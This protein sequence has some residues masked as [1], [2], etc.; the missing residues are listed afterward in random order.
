MRPTPPH[1]SADSGA[2]DAP[3]SDGT[4]GSQAIAD[5]RQ[6]SLGVLFARGAGALP[7]ALVVVGVVA[8]PRHVESEFVYAAVFDGE[9]F[10]PT[11]WGASALVGGPSEARRPP[12]CAERAPRC[13]NGS[14][15]DEF[16]IDDILRSEQWRAGA[17]AGAFEI[18]VRDTPLPDHAEPSLKWCIVAG[19]IRRHEVPGEGLFGIGDGGRVTHLSSNIYAGSTFSQVLRQPLWGDYTDGPWALGTTLVHAAL[20]AF[21][22]RDR[23]RSFKRDSHFKSFAD[24]MERLCP[25]RP[26]Y[27]AAELAHRESTAATIIARICREERIGEIQALANRLGVADKAPAEKVST[28]AGNRRARP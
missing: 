13:S 26:Y 9:R 16:S 25:S 3:P 10:L 15:I 8:V 17:F 21:I 22:Q 27:T 4:I 24:E 18:F 19:V 2:E 12:N 20:P 23:E 1:P 11:F 6:T 5:A 28:A 7:G 14:P